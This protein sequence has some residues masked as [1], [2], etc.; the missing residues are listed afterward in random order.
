MFFFKT[1][2]WLIYNVLLITGVQQS[3]SVIHIYTFFNILF[4][5]GLSQD[6]EYINSSLC[7]TQ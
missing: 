2:V 3:G 6:F 1:E 5:Y 4:H 7:C